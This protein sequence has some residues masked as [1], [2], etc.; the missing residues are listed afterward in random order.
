MPD[1]KQQTSQTRGSLD[2]TWRGWVELSGALTPSPLVSLVPF[3]DIV[4]RERDIHTWQPGVCSSA[5]T[6]SQGAALWPDFPRSSQDIMAQCHWAT[7]LGR[8]SAWL[9]LPPPQSTHPQCHTWYHTWMLGQLLPGLPCSPSTR[10][11][12]VFKSKG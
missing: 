2:Q 11:H 8:G 1:N 4:G 10:L 7:G 12:P 3:A 5:M 9:G 6:S